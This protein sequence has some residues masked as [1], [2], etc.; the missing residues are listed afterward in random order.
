MGDERALVGVF[1]GVLVLTL[2][3]AGAG[4]GAAGGGGPH[5]QALSLAQYTGADTVA[6][7][8]PENGSV[9]MAA[10][11]DGAVVAID[12][13]H[14]GSVDDA[15]LAPMVTALAAHGASV[16]YLTG[17]PSEDFNASLRRADA[18]VVL[19]AGQPYTTS[20]LDAVQAFA[21]A[22]GRVLLARQASASS[23]SLGLIVL[24]GPIDGGA[25]PHANE[26]ASRFDVAF[27]NGYLYDMHAYSGN[28]RNVYATPTGESDLTAG[29]DRVVVHEAVPVVGP[30]ALVT[31]RGTTELSTT[32][33]QRPYGVVV[34]SGNVVA[35]GDTSLL[36]Q[37]YSRRADNEVLL[38]NL[39]DFLVS[40]H[41]QPAAAPTGGAG[42]PGGSRG[43]A[44]GGTS[45]P[46]PP[47]PPS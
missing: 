9:T 22:G 3:L 20:Q 19:G 15:L 47:T 17:A 33:T 10:D 43:S 46:A 6:H 4:A 16:E 21:D 7:A 45:R 1:A 28:Y 25:T 18:Y 32:R 27:G 13:A 36:G 31:T 42:P 44:R 30:R 35:V 14:G 38:G 29:V 34:R 11:A 2:L 8:P 23:P 40:G 41:K 12:V 39:L 24:G 37:A 26:L 5:V